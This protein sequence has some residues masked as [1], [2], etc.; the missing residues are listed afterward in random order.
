[1]I[2]EL[3]LVIKQ[4]KVK[5][6]LISNNLLISEIVLPFVIHDNRELINE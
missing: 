5:K 4:Q 3:K 2:V 6:I 1:M